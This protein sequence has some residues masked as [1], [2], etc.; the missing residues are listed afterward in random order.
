M[1]RKRLMHK[2][3]ARRFL[4]IVSTVRYMLDLSDDKLVIKV[5]ERQK[6]RQQYEKLDSK[7]QS[8]VVHEGQGKNCRSICR[9]I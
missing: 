6:G 4:D 2:K 5:R 3:Y 8:L 9:I 1:R 7:K